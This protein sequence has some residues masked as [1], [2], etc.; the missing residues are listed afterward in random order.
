MADTIKGGA[1]HIARRLF[2]SWIWTKPPYY[3][4]LWVW[5]LGKCNHKTV[6][7]YG[8]V[9]NRGE[10]LVSLKETQEQTKYK[11]GWRTEKISKDQ[12]WYFYEDCRKQSMIE[13]TKTTAGMFVKVL[14]YNKYQELSNYEYDNEPNK[15]P[16]RTQ[17]SPNTI[18]KNDTKM[19][20]NEKKNTHTMTT[21]EKKVLEIFNRVQE[22][23][24]RDKF[25]SPKGFGS[26]LVYWLEDY[27]L[28][29]IERAVVASRKDSYW[30]DILTPTI[31]FRQKNERKEPVD[32][33][34]DLKS[35]KADSGG[36]YV[37]PDGKTFSSKEEFKRYVKSK[38]W[39]V[40]I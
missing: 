22:R 32:Y 26:N 9:F 31:L 15:N 28:E 12:A 33:I 14:N 38:G 7:R 25:K 35:R 30:R 19:I 37:A 11:V 23:E 5:L 40:R 24:G 34:G 27:T 20:K 3:I 17:Q 39:E 18:N 6:E 21:Q 2:N 1:F 36:K 8:Q 4:K 10:C 13:T 29:D 16:T